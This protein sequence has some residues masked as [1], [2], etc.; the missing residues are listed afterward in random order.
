MVRQLGNENR[1]KLVS[2][3]AG[4]GGLDLGLELA[5]FEAVAVNELEPYACD[6]LRANRLLPSLDSSE[7]EAWFKK[8]LGQRC[9]KNVFAP[10]VEPLEQRVA[11]A[12][13]Q[14]PFLRCAEI[15]EGDIRTISSETIKTAANVIV[16][17]LDLVAGG[18]PC[19]PFSR[20]GK[21]ESVNVQT[22]QLF[23]EFVRV[24]NDLRPR[25]F[26]FENV[27]GLILTKTE[28]VRASCP[29]CRQDTLLS[30]DDRLLY[31]DG[32][33]TA[34]CSSCGGPSSP[35]AK[36]K[37]GGSLDIILHEF[38][39]I[40]YRCHNTILNAADYGVPQLRERLIIVGSRDNEAFSWPE[41]TNSNPA[42][43]YRTPLF[44]G[45]ELQAPWITMRK[46]LWSDGHP[47]YGYLRPDTAVLWVKNVVRPHDEPVTWSLDRPAPTIGAHQSA[48]L[49]IAPHGVPDEQLKRQ[50][51]HV[52]GKRQGDFPPVEVE[53]TYLSDADLLALQSFPKY[54][55]LHGTRMQR[56]FQIGNAV[57]VELGRHLGLALFAACKGT[58]STSAFASLN[59]ACA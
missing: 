35:Y 18:A 1:P 5:G 27:K 8:Q 32:D 10:D 4:A 17:G 54:W 51:W 22:G 3:F 56:A 47:K 45:T 38:E 52:L 7:Y 6:S 16:G 28:I 36:M 19:Q 23:R 30:F 11:G 15:L 29:A 40:G 9:Y 59:C 57:P 24:V 43:N 13:G 58:P 53:H 12:I 55:Y 42:W 37:A 39:A 21:R 34:R 26:L 46:A 31:Y 48:K 14:F 20:A 49:A 33:L 2:L 44:A 25:W 41:A 50:Q